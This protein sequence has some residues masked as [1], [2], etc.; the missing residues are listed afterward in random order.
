MCGRQ[1]ASAGWYVIQGSLS[2]SFAFVFTSIEWRPHARV[3]MM[4]VRRKVTNDIDFGK[5]WDTDAG[6]LRMYLDFVTVPA[7]RKVWNVGATNTGTESQATA[8]WSV[9]AV[10][11]PLTKQ[12][13]IDIY[14]ILKF[15]YIRWS[16]LWIT[17]SIS[18]GLSQLNFNI[19]AKSSKFLDLTYF[20]M[21]YEVAQ[22]VEALRYQPEGRGFDSRWCRWDFSLT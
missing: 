4:T 7:S 21:W 20:M 9:F 2:V 11:R 18:V 15:I 22:L 10:E 16:I 1:L 17:A 5:T 3:R 12:Q 13:P 8:R 19:W 14:R 6:F